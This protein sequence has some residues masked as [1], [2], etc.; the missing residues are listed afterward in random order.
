MRRVLG[1]HLGLFRGKKRDGLRSANSFPCVIEDEK[2][3][4]R[5]ERGEA[6]GA[7]R[8]T[9]TR[10]RQGRSYNGLYPRYVNIQ[11]LQEL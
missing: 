3:T 9:S 7:I 2:I 11:E 10:I 5:H 8:Y 6:M 1:R 4:M